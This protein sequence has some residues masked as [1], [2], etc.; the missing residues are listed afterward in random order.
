MRASAVCSRTDSTPRE[1]LGDLKNSFTFS[2]SKI[3]VTSF[4]Q[5]LYTI[6]A[7]EKQLDLLSI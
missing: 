4:C 1:V 6:G 2:N 7:T 3:D 5:T